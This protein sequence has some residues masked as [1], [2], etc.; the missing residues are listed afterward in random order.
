MENEIKILGKDFY[1][2]PLQQLAT[3]QKN[4]DDKFGK[5]G[6]DL[7]YETG[8]ESFFKLSRDM[9]KF[10]DNKE[11][12]YQVL[13][14]LISNFGFGEIEIIEI[15]QKELKAKV[16]VKTN[17]FAKEYIKLFGFQKKAIDY[18]L[19]GIIA[20]YFSK[21]FEKNVE[22]KEESCIGKRNQICEFVVGKIS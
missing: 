10:Y 18:L 6:L 20:G 21:F 11:K 22:C 4:L 12:F 15:K 5:K 3:L 8:K 9:E 2:Q 14:S 7:L 16:K 19:S 1:L 13:S 17:P